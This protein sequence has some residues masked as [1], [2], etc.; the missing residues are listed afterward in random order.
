M[1]PWS[2]FELQCLYDVVNDAN[3]FDAA[4]LIIPRTPNAVRQKMSAL[5]KDAGIIPKHIGPKA[6]PRKLCEYERAQVGSTMLAE[7]IHGMAA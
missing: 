6:K 3:W 2:D 5:R 7:A 4:E 1:K